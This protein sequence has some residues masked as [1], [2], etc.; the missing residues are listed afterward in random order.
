ME[1]KHAQKSILE[2]KVFKIPIGEFEKELNMEGVKEKK[3]KILEVFTSFNKLQ[4]Q[5]EYDK[6][7]YNLHRACAKGDVELI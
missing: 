5:E 7:K 2:S 6:I 1:D 3:K 4:T